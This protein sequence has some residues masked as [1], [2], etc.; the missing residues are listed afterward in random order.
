M[1]VNLSDGSPVTGIEKAGST[2]DYAF[3]KCQIESKLVQ[4]VSLI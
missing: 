3:K 4:I 1:F 2:F